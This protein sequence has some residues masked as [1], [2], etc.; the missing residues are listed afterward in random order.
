VEPVSATALLKTAY[1]LVIRKVVGLITDQAQ[2]PLKAGKEKFSRAWRIP[3]PALAG[4]LQNVIAEAYV[5]TVES[6]VNSYLDKQKNK[7]L[8]TSEDIENEENLRIKL[9]ALQKKE[10]S[11]IAPTIETID[12]LPAGQFDNDQELRETL[13]ASVKKALDNLPHDLES[14]FES[15]LLPT[16]TENIWHQISK[17]LEGKEGSNVVFA[18]LFQALSR[19]E[20][21]ADNAESYASQSV[22]KIVELSAQMSAL[23][24]NNERA[25]K[26]SN[27]Q[28][29]RTKEHYRR[30]LLESH[31]T[32]FVPGLN[33]RLPVEEAWDELLIGVSPDPASASESL[34]RQISRYH[35][36]ERLAENA[37]RDSKVY[38]A[39][40]VLIGEDRLVIIGG[41]GSG[42]STLG[43]RLSVW[44]A[45]KGALAIRVSLKRVGRLLREGVAF[46][47]ALLNVALDGSGIPEDIGK[48]ALASPD[49]LIA[50]GLDECDP[51]RAE[52]ANHLASWASGHPHC[53]ICVMTR[54]VGHTASLL[55]GF[56]H[57]ELLPL[58][59]PAIS[60]FTAELIAVKV[61]D[62]ERCS[63]LTSEFTRLV[64]GNK[65]ERRVASIAARNPLLLSFLLALFLEGKPLTN[66]RAKLFE[67]IIDLIRRSPMSDRINTIDIEASLA[68]RVIEVAAWRHINSPDIDLKTLSGEVARDLEIQ[69]DKPPLA[70]KSL[71]ELGLKFWEER[72]LIERLTLGQIE[73]YTFVHLSLEEYLV[74][75][76]ISHMKDNDLRSWLLD[77]R[78]EVRWRQPILLAGGAGAANRIV[79]LLLELDEPTDL[80]SIEAVIAASCL[81]EA[82]DVSEQLAEQVTAKLRYR[83][84][85]EI[86][87][88]TIEAG[89]GL[90]RLTQLA[91]ETAKFI[92]V[93]LLEHKQEWTR[94]AAFSARLAAG[95]QYV[96]LDQVRKWLDGIKFVRMLHFTGEPAERRISDLPEEAYDLQEFA[97]VQAI[98]R[99]FEELS[100]EDARAEAAKYVKQIRH[101]M[102][103][104][105]LYP[106]DEMLSRYDSADIIDAAFAEDRQPISISPE[107]WRNSDGSSP[108]VI[109]I[110]AII[111][112]AKASTEG[113]LQIIHNLSEAE[114]TN[115]S[116]LISA[117]RFLKVNYTVFDALAKRREED[118]FQEVLRATIFILGLNPTE[119]MS[120]AETVFAKL[121]ES[122]DASIT[123]FIRNIPV[124]VNW[125][126]AKEANLNTSKIMRALGHPS[127]VVVGAA[128]SLL[129]KGV[130]EEDVRPLVLQALEIDGKFTLEAMAGIVPR[131]WE[132]EEA[133]RI[134]LRR[135]KGKP[136]PGFGH[137]YRALGLVVI[138]CEDSSTCGEVAKALLDGLYSEEHTAA[139]AAAEV[140]LA[141]SLT[142]SQTL[143]QLLKRAFVYWMERAERERRETPA[144]IVGSGENQSSFRVVEPD[145][146]V[147]LVK[148][149]TELDALD[150]EEL[151]NLSSATQPGISGEAIRALAAYAAGQPDLLRSLLT[152]IKE[153]L[154]PYPS[155]T[156]LNLLHALLRLPAETLQ[157]VEPELLAIAQAE[158]PAL[159]ASIISSLTS[160][161]VT[162][163]T[164]L[165]TARGAINDPAPGVRNSAVR[166][167]R[168]LNR[169]G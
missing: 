118:A 95:K 146:L 10:I 91:P 29:E 109:L 152:R 34:A 155:S 76:Y 44:A 22:E 103:S 127:R 46:D 124:K 107:R 8:R 16:L 9:K 132:P 125:E 72:R 89:E 156:A 45:N 13:I 84:T 85:S 74:G 26:E 41:P 23:Q 92:S 157:K 79:P 27:E 153:G 83:L 5:K 97:F 1:P 130:N 143:Q 40:A 63:A 113:E 161:W 53:H 93:D 116:I 43:R 61:D 111:S 163:D 88:V 24:Q 68:E 142:N 69:A 80:T 135:L 7:I 30:W 52:M 158:I 120:E 145:P 108:D 33:V 134:L 78:R 6:I 99:L 50:D 39:D 77:A 15:K 31:E 48:A 105:M 12:I 112:A 28:I 36:W 149:L 160:G 2:K 102:T 121:K 20:E 86:P 162:R 59:E 110:E 35:E 38:G 100:Q 129:L 60:T 71:A 147:T 55:P 18:F 37:R 56:S 131:L 25:T 106:L 168:L 126:R 138:W 151:L 73:A 150:T 96:T 122:D 101:N 3:S 167:I 32:F 139:L 164:A 14:K 137:I 62:P 81:A 117:F 169:K 114:F 57:A 64:V 128:A 119:L 66:R 67:Q 17:S 4:V 19:I 21:T 90:R 115:L 75:L 133:A 47:T 123:T 165:K 98:G 94:L 166:T 87:L 104:G 42:K 49:Y 70:A 148:L 141:L 51:N 58:N 82:G 54:P 140:L 11:E 159:R 136:A 65:E 154:S 144:R